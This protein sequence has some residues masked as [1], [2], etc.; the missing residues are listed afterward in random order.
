MKGKHNVGQERSEV[1]AKQ[2]GESSN[3]TTRQDKSGTTPKQCGK[4]STTDSP[5][6][7][8][9]TVTPGTA[10][11]VGSEQSRDATRK[12]IT[13][14]VSREP[15]LPLLSEHRIEN[16]GFNARKRGSS[17]ESQFS[18][19][20]ENSPSGQTELN[21][22]RKLENSDDNA[23]HDQG[24]FTPNLDEDGEQSKHCHP[25]IDSLDP[26]A[27][28][29]A[30]II[31]SLQIKC[32]E[33]EKRIDDL[34]AMLDR[35][36]NESRLAQFR[37][38]T[39]AQELDHVRRLL[40]RPR[41][42]SGSD[43]I[44]LVDDLNFEIQ[45]VA[46]SLVDLCRGG[47]VVNGGTSVT[48]A[49]STAYVSRIVGSAM[50]DF[51]QKDVPGVFCQFALQAG[52]AI[53]CHFLI[54][55]WSCDANAAHFL[56]KAFAGVQNQNTPS[57]AGHWRALTKATSKYSRTGYSE[58]VRATEG[59]ISAYVV[60][61]LV[62]WRRLNQHCSGL[63]EADLIE[64]VNSGTTEVVRLA[65]QL[66]KVLGLEVT[67]EEWMV[68]VSVQ[69]AIFDEATMENASENL[70]SSA[71]PRLILC[72]TALGLVRT[73]VEP[74]SS[75]SE[76]VDAPVIQYETMQKMKVVVR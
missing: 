43:L 56:S 48:W 27:A 61:V 23:G 3:R 30:E 15:K 18:C 9:D 40:N 35:E 58:L 74:A 68:R 44:K 5:S 69:D 28:N 16:T 55:A 41:S 46:A 36:E 6:M 22:R 26:T 49:E 37:H 38:E 76:A 72:V 60:H 14:G 50:I 4:H 17:T 71:D 33:R 12:E 63:A 75:D 57:I 29:Q 7:D 67:D 70:A 11:T 34:L 31:T 52:M 62:L 59:C 73:I 10:P 42:Y 65:S 39:R 13:Q 8:E 45:Q 47:T 54:Q 32:R 51:L 24:F 19:H 1:G 64:Q 20:R 25:I 53:Y 66:D 21:K 2:P